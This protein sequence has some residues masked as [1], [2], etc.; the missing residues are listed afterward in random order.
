MVRRVSGWMTLVFVLGTLVPVVVFGWLLRSLFG[1]ALKNARILRE[2]LRAPAEVVE[3]TET[4]ASVA[5]RRGLAIALEVRPE[6]GAP[7]RA[8]ARHTVLTSR[9]PEVGRGARVTVRYR[10]EAPSEAAIEG[11]EIDD[12][13]A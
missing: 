4:D 1:G 11:I 5:D 12:V 10:R 8:T 3:V 2:G 6:G 13:R 9:L 7:F